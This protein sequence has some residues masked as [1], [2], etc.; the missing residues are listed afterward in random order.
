MLREILFFLHYVG[1]IVIVMISL[2]LL[3]KKEMA[4]ELR[5]KIS[6]YLVSAAH[7]QLLTGFILSILLFSEIDKFKI[8]IKIVCAIVVA[9]ISTKERKRIMQNGSPNHSMILTI[10]LLVFAAILTAFLM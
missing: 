1:M 5:K 8:T 2:I 3:I 6:I 10:L 4:S 7:T 9:I